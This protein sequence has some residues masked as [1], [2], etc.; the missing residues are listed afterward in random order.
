MR[1]AG[2]LLI[3]GWLVAGAA[4]ATPISAGPHAPAVPFCDAAALPGLAAQWARVQREGARPILDRAEEP[5]ADAR[6]WR[7]ALAEDY[8]RVLEA[9]RHGAAGPALRNRADAP[10]GTGV[11]ASSPGTVPCDAAARHRDRAVWTLTLAGYSAREIADV[12]SG[13]LSRR[14]VDRARALLMAGRPAAEA[15]AFLDSRWRGSSAGADSIASRTQP[16]PPLAPGLDRHLVALCARHGLDPA[17][18]R[19][20]VLAESAGDPRAVS[21]AGAIGLMQLMPGTAAAL[22]VDPWDPF[23]NLRG[24]VQYL[25]GLLAVYEDPVLAL[26]AYNAGPQHADRVRAGSSVPY[27]E[28]R[29][30]L[31]AIRAA[32]PLP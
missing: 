8:A 11:G 12:V 30:Y 16:A 29:R 32:Y 23:D 25:A 19:A 18:V 21:P 9:V 20:V 5:A 14:D 22:G 10:A 6:A 27:R 2:A 7:A 28:T 1:L 3:G 4:A 15:S 31:D 13:H 17:L 26:V 24:G